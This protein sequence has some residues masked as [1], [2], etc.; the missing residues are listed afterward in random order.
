MSWEIETEA[1][2]EARRKTGAIDGRFQVCHPAAGFVDSAN[3]LAEAFEIAD[4]YAARKMPDGGLFLGDPFEI[5]V[6]D[7][8][9]RRGRA[10]TW[11]RRPKNGTYSVKYGDK[12]SKDAFWQCVDIRN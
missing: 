10:R 7:R 4:R 5:E 3:T 12:F 11:R 2:A 8:M 6:Y 1:E 9:A